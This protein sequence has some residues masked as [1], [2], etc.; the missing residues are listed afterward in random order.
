M[1][2]GGALILDTLVSHMLIRMY[3]S[4]ENLKASILI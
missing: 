1:H 2:E 3:K 4:H